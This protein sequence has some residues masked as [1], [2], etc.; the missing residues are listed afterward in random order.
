MTSNVLP[1]VPTAP[2]SQRYRPEVYQAFADLIHSPAIY[3]IGANVHDLE[4]LRLACLEKV[5][6]HGPNAKHDPDSDFRLDFLANINARWADDRVLYW[7]EGL[8]YGWNLLVFEP[9]PA[10]LLTATLFHGT[11]PFIFALY[12]LPVRLPF[13]NC[14]IHD[15]FS[16]CRRNEAAPPLTAAEKAIWDEIGREYY[17]CDHP[18]DWRSLDRQRR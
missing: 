5:R 17:G 6:R 7:D 4:I 18:F 11:R 1:A 15:D 12:P 8:G 16:I 14:A 13:A 3:G 2:V 10:V 9:P